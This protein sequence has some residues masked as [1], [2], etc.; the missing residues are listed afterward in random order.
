MYSALLKSIADM[1]AS[2]FDWQSMSI[3]NQATTE[4]IKDKRSTA[5]ACGYANEALMLSERYAT[6]QKSKP[7][8]RFKSLLKKFRRCLATGKI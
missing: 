8:R 7:R 2:L 4:V 5:K 1:L 6:F 3:K